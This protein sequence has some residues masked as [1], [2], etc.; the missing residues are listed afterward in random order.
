MKENEE[1]KRKFVSDLQ[2]LLLDVPDFSPQEDVDI[3]RSV[4]M[5]KNNLQ[6]YC[7]TH[8]ISEPL[9]LKQGRPFNYASSPKPPVPRV[10]PKLPRK[11]ISTASCFAANK[12]H[13]SDINSTQNL[14]LNQ[15]ETRLPDTGPIPVITKMPLK[16]K[17]GAKPSP[18]SIP[19]PPPPPPPVSSSFQTESHDEERRYSYGS[20][21]NSNCSSIS[22]QDEI[23]THKKDNLKHV[24]GP[25]TPGGT[26]VRFMEP[27]DM[28]QRALMKKFRAIHVHSTPKRGGLMESGSIEVSNTWSE[29]GTSMENIHQYA[30]DP[31]M[32][33]FSRDFTDPPL[34]SSVRSAADF[35][36]ML[37]SPGYNS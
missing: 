12:V 18:L 4:G 24:S 16:D 21:P 34:Q 32:T 5:L 17:E 33:R 9:Q 25:K 29:W 6:S 37:S 10:K 8:K 15:K 20:L 13:V 31:D 23:A 28:L 7:K 35:E 26:P 11:S 2:H 27:T 1:A 36:S 19:P 14:D 30:S 22:L 3:V